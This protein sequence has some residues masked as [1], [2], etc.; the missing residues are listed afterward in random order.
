MVVKLVHICT[1]PPRGLGGP[2]ANT[3]S[4]APQNGLCEGGL[5]AHPQE[6]LHALKCFV[7]AAEVIFCA[8]TQY[9]YTCKLAVSDRQVHR[10][11][12]L[13]SGLRNNCAS[14]IKYIAKEQADFNRK[15]SETNPLKKLDWNVTDEWI[16]FE[17]VRHCFWRPPY[18]GGTGQIAPVAPPPVG[19]TASIAIKLAIPCI[20]V[21]YSNPQKQVAILRMVLESI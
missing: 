11:G 2:R 10:T 17:Q 13:V 4:G 21:K 3:K 14:S 1:G 19:G 8:C 20:T 9:I 6:I 15:Y 16:L 12:S 18:N 5:G 7:G